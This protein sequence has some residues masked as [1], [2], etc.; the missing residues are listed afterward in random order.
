MIDNNFHIQMT[1]INLF[2]LFGI[3]LLSNCEKE[4]LKE[5]HVPEQ[6][7][8]DVI[9]DTIS[10]IGTPVLD[11]V[12]D[13][14]RT[15]TSTTIS[16]MHEQTGF[17]SITNVFDAVSGVIDYDKV[18][19][20]IKFWLDSPEF[21]MFPEIKKKAISRSIQELMI[22]KT[23]NKKKIPSQTKKFELQFSDGNGKILL[24]FIRLT[25]IENNELLVE[26][27]LVTTTFEVAPPYVIVTE[28]DCNILSCDRTDNIVYMPARITDAHTTTII[29]M[30]IGFMIGLS[31]QIN[32]NLGNYRKQI[33]R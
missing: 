2:I 5:A 33:T 23:N 25:S 17:Y 15:E 27:Y 14:L 3:I 13:I 12:I 7:L 29:N 32:K 26:K 28:S 1:I 31:N 21:D 8:G 6:N 30:N 4:V 19:E 22:F 9:K 18:G 16:D 11:T 24:L 20:L 10:S